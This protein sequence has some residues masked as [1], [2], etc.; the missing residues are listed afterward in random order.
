[1]F[2]E[3]KEKETEDLKNLMDE[4]TETLKSEFDT[5]VRIVNCNPT[6]FFANITSSFSSTLAALF[7]CSWLPKPKTQRN[8]EFCKTVNHIL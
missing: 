1:M 3:V 6:T 7:L 2:K 5:K 4:T 8:V